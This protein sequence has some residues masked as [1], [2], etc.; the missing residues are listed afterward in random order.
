MFKYLSKIKQVFSVTG[1]LSA[2]AAAAGDL[3][4]KVTHEAENNT[5]I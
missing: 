4:L 2:A 3:S 1:V 5:L